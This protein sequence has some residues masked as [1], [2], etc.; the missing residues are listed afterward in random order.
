VRDDDTDFQKTAGERLGRYELVTRIARGGMAEVWLARQHGELGFSRLVALKMIRAE[1]ASDPSFRKMFLEEARLAAKLHH[2]NAVEVLDLGEHGR[3]LYLAMAYVE[4]DSIAGLLGRA[5]EQGLGAPRLPPGVAVRVIADAC[6]GLHAA[7]EL[8]DDEGSPLDLVHRDVSPHNV[9]VGLDGVSRITDFGIAKALGRVTDDTDTGQVKG[10]LSYLSPEQAKRLPPD[11]RS[12]L[13][14]LGIV[15]WEALTG[16]R[17][18]R[19]DEAV[20]TLLN[21]KDK[22]IPDPRSVVPIPDALALA[23]LR[24]L[25]RDP[26]ARYRTA[27]EMRRALEAAA[28]AEQLVATADEVSDFVADLC[29]EE[30]EQRRVAV[31]A[32]RSSLP[33][34]SPSSTSSPPSEE[35]DRDATVRGGRKSELTST[36]TSSVVPRHVVSDPRLASSP[37]A[38][39]ARGRGSI[40]LAIVVTGVA[41]A[42][43]A[44]GIARLSRPATDPVRAP[45]ADGAATVPVE[46]TSIGAGP[47]VAPASADASARS[48]GSAPSADGSSSAGHLPHAGSALRSASPRGSSSATAAAS[49]AGPG[50]SAEPSTS[51]EGPMY[52]SPYRR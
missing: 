33:P 24:A 51:A 44:F 30:I 8:T 18:F 11:R 29:K 20:D 37:G 49:A 39:A 7:H 47:V 40:A 22:A 12:D 32:S 10:K 3:T 1:H 27:E 52:K 48:A 42:A 6:A 38:P 4:G 19:A 21:V 43:S 36:R 50:A 16:E 25:E 9:L 31:R 17:L 34:A 15:L 45:R 14:A 41:V 28:R 23:V 26:A 13:F 46:G 5:K 2:A 35:G